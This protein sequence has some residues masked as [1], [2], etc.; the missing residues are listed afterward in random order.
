MA[1]KHLRT[2]GMGNVIDEPKVKSKTKP[3]PWREP[4][5]LREY[6]LE[7]ERLFWKEKPEQREQIQEFVESLKQDWKTQDKRDDVR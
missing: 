4:D 7:R 1:K 2:D 3:K 5:W 6:R